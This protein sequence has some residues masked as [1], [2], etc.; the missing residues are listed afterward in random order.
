MRGANI[1]GALKDISYKV[2]FSGLQMAAFMVYSCSSF[3]CRKEIS[4]FWEP[5]KSYKIYSFIQGHTN[6][7]MHTPWASHVLSVPWYLNLLFSTK[8]RKT[9]PHTL[10]SVTLIL[11]WNRIFNPI[12]FSLSSF[13]LG[14]CLLVAIH[15][16]PSNQLKH[17]ARRQDNR[18]KWT[19]MCP[20]YS[21]NSTGGELYCVKS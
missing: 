18:S 19:A 3:F 16:R 6:T 1:S 14:P 21:K 13:T 9:A 2:K 17:L 7:H 20:L 8:K 10:V 5:G 11:V 12:E 4:N 15:T